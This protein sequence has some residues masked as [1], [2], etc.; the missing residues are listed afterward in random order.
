MSENF[1]N[2]FISELKEIFD[3]EQQLVEALPEMAKAADSDELKDVFNSHLQETK[4]QVTRLQKV[5]KILRLNEETIPCIAMQGMIQECL[6]SINTY[7]QSYLRDAA[8]ISKAQRIEHYEMA[9][10]GALR[11]YAKHLEL[12]DIASILQESL[13]EEGNANKDLTAI[14]EGGLFA[15]GVNQK[16]NE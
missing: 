5:F 12:D 7:P 6:D 4:L 11:T 13:N 1:K 2:Y 9:V 3:A 10:Y 8:L 16:A 15:A 14:A